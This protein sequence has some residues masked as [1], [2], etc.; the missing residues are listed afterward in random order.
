MDRDQMSEAWAVEG[1]TALRAHRAFDFDPRDAGATILTM[2][3]VLGQMETRI[4]RITPAGQ[5]PVAVSQLDTICTD[6]AFDGQRLVCMAY[7]GARTHVLAFTPTGDAPQP[8]G[9]LGGRFLS[10]RPTRE[11]WVSGWA[12][13]GAGAL[14]MTGQM[15]IDLVSRRLVTVPA[16]LR[17]D[18]ITA[19]GSV[20][21][22]LTHDM[23][24]TR[25]RLYSLD[26]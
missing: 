4:T 22:I 16:D 7:D 17:A 24:S 8:I 25:V 3:A 14:N 11:G 20:A 6:H 1:D 15:A 23:S 26:R 9:S 2:A 18:E 19:A 5:T 10:S 12:M 13:T 21:A